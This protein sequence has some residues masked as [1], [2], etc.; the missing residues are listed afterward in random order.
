MSY[1]KLLE[2]Q[3]RRFFGDP[4]QLP[5]ELKP[6]LSSV[7]EAYR[8]SD[9]DRRSLERSLE[10]MSGELT[11]RYE[12]LRTELADRQRAQ[13]ALL[14]EKAEQE[15][16]IKKLEDTHSQLV[17]SEKM[18]SIGQLAAGLAHEINNPVGFV[19]S[20][21]GTLHDYVN[22]LLEL[23]AAFEKEEEGLSEAAR[24]RLAELKKRVELSFV[25]EDAPALLTESSEGLRRVRQIIRD[26]TDF[27]HVDDPH[28]QNTD[29][30]KGLESTLNIVHNEVRYVADVHK[31]YGELPEVE[32]LP[33][34]LNQ[35][36]LN[37]L[38]N[39][40]Q[41]IKGKRGTITVRTGRPDEAHVFIEIADNGEG[42]SPENLKRIFNPFFTTKPVGK[43]T[44]LGLSVSYG[45]VAKHQGRI[46]VSSRPGEGTTFRIVLP[47]K[48]AAS[49]ASPND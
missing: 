13:Q 15:A 11:E 3:L 46:E 25:R 38:V 28:W 7:D 18:A 16:L 4:E 37:M 22:G 8:T 20:N 26:L 36:F 48:Q 33:S 1:H 6:F 24:Q 30:H 14:K 21:L 17:Q 34:Q 49:P 41:A 44:G 27:S 19:N 35:V 43:G 47:V 40:A 42:I 12:Q 32:C 10:L 31:E 5:P 45:I 23:T 9:D 39:A 29:L 2:R